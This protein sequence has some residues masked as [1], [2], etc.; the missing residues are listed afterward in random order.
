MCLQSIL[1][2]VCCADSLPSLLGVMCSP[3]LSFNRFTEFLAGKDHVSPTEV[4]EHDWSFVLDEES[5]SENDTIDYTEED[6]TPSPQRW[7]C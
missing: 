2:V 5:D 6:S 4:G 3:C 1:L 7:V